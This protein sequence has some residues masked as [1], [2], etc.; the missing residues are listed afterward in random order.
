MPPFAFVHTVY[1]AGHIKCKQLLNSYQTYRIIGREV[2]TMMVSTKGRYALQVCLDLAQQDPEVYISLREVAQRQNISM[3]YLESIVAMLNRAGLVRSLR[4][5][6]G[7]YRLTRRPEDCA[8]GEILQLTEGSMAPVYCL[9]PGGA[10]DKAGSCMTY[11]MWRQLDQLID[12]YLRRVTLADLL[13]G[14]LPQELPC[15]QP[16]ISG[17]M[18]S[19]WKCGG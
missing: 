18:S 4:G 5:K 9:E 2:R 13:Q 11:P 17:Q 1:H 15:P 12:G 16:E 7:G 14:R 8:V 6:G 19:V 3:K 10:C